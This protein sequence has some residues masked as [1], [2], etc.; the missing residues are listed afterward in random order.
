VEDI[1]PAIESMRERAAL[2]P[3]FFG[4]GDENA[5]IRSKT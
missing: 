5:E 4:Y 1:L 2:G 3:G